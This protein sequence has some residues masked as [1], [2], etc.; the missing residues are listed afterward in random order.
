[1]SDNQASDASGE[2]SQNRNAGGVFIAVGTVAG[3][4]IGA[5]LGQPSIGFLAGLALGS[6]LAL[7]IWLKER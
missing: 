1:M 5:L 2:S 4:V 3:A 6:I 7:A